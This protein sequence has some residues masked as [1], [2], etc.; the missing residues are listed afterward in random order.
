MTILVDILELAVCYDQ[1]NLGAC[2]CL[3]KIARRTQAIVDAWDTTPGSHPEWGTADLFI[4]TERVD[5]AVDPE[6]REFV[7]RRVKQRND[8]AALRARGK[9]GG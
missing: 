8:T 4:G 2:A 5:D 7:G 3:E 9:P 6:L 1:L